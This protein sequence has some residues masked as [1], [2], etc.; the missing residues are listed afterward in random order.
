MLLNG[1][2]YTVKYKKY[3][4]SKYEKEKIFDSIKNILIKLPEIIFAYVHGSFTEKK[5]FGDIDLAVF[6]KDDEI[7]DQILKYEIELEIKLEESIKYPLDVRVLNN[8]PL[9]FKYN[10]IKRG[11]LLFEKEADSRVDFETKTLNFYFDF[12]PFRKQYLE[13]V[14]NFGD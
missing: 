13:E 9:S 5:G 3:N 10:V 1:G 8:A 14:L 12:A 11:T 2:S 7:S 4:I 6:L